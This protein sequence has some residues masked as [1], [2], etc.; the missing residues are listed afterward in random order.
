[1][2][3]EPVR[4]KGEAKVN[5]RNPDYKRYEGHVEVNSWVFSENFCH[6]N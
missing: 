2:F 4:V 6:V 1:V 3:S 5:T